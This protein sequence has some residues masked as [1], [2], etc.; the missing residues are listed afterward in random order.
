LA[1]REK[2]LGADHPDVATSLNNLAIL[3]ESQGRY[4]EAELL[5]RRSLAIRE[6]QL[7]VDNPHVGTSLNNLAVLYESQGRYTEAEP[8][9]L[10][11]LA[12]DEKVYGEDHPEI[13]TDL[14]NLAFLYN[15]QGN[16]A[17][18]KTLS[19]RALNI[20]Q[21]AL[22]NHHPDTQ[23]VLFATKMFNVQVLL[24]CDSG[25]L[26]GLLQALA[27]QANLPNSDTETKLILL[28]TIAT[29]PQLLQHLRQSL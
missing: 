17:E 26:L 3:Y 7:G 2:Q 24:D 21:K 15:A 1:I 28:E 11:S 29:N 27:Q 8:L 16:Y 4:T 22:G 9:Y 18:A 19:Q 13:A 14:N 25:T 23:T 20:L 5:Y 6:K 12:I 10:R